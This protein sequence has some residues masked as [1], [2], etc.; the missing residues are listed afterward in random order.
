MNAPSPEVEILWT[1]EGDGTA[2]AS[3]CGSDF[4]TL[5]YVL[6][7]NGVEVGCN[8]DGTS[9]G[10]ASEISWS[11]TRGSTWTV[12]VDGYAG[13]RGFFELRITGPDA[14]PDPCPKPPR[15]EIDGPPC[16]TYHSPDVA[17][18]CSET[19]SWTPVDLAEWYEVL[20]TEPDGSTVNVGSTKRANRVFENDDGTTTVVLSSTWTPILDCIEVP[21]ALPALG[22]VYR[23]AVRACRAS[24]SGDLCGPWAGDIRYSRPPLFVCDLG[25]CTMIP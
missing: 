23:Y 11:V 21:C 20:R 3:A 9:C 14:P 1:A 19:F 25:S 12:I 15:F 10:W 6:D 2:S 8:D 17:C 16:G 13:A 7:A 24:A 4:D 5:V 22:A 18:G